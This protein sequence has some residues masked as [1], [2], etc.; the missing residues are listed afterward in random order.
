M[1]KDIFPSSESIE[2]FPKPV[3]DCNMSVNLQKSEA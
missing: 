3:I 2:A 1:S